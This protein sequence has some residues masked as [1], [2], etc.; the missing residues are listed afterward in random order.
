MLEILS[1]EQL[2]EHFL[3]LQELYYAA[4]QELETVTRA[5]SR[6]SELLEESVGKFTWKQ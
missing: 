2:V 3:S 5:S 4:I 1:K 6:L